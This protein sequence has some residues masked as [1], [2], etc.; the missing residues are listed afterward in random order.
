M[1]RALLELCGRGRHIA[2]SR[3]DLGQRTRHCEPE[4]ERDQCQYAQVVDRY[5]ETAWNTAAAQRL[6]ARAHRSRDDHRHE[7]ERDHELELPESERHN[8]DQNGDNG[9][10]ESSTSCAAGLNV[11]RMDDRHDRANRSRTRGVA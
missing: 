2:D 10:D 1:V 4:K 5:A 11:R 7:D 6:D 9:R 8:D 3:L